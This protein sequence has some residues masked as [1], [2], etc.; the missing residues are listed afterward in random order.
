MIEKVILT[1]FNH[2]HWGYVLQPVLVEDTSGSLNVLSIVSEQSSCFQVLTDVQ[3]QIVRYSQRYA[4]EVLMKSY[5][6]ER[7][8]FDF[9]KTVKPNIIEHY[10][11]PIIE[12][13]HLKIVSLLFDSGMELYHRSDVKKRILYESDHIHYSAEPAHVVFHFIRDDISGLRYF[14]RIKHKDSTIDLKDKNHAVLRHEP[15]VVAVDDQLF[16][17]DDIDSKKLLPFFTKDYISVPATSEQAYIKKFVVNCVRNYE[18]VSEGLSI[19]EVTPQRKACLSLEKDL[20]NQTRL[21]LEFEYE[22]KRYFADDKPQRIVTPFIENGKN[23]IE[24]FERDKEWE[25]SN[26]TLLGE[27]GLERDMAGYF[28]VAGQAMSSGQELTMIHWLQTHAGLLEQFHFD[29]QISDKTYFL[30]DVTMETRIDD[31]QDWFDVK[32]IVVIGEYRIPFT[33]FKNHIL[34]YQKEYLLPDGSVVIL[35]DEWFS[36]YQELM[37]FGKR[38][39]ESFRLSKYYFPIIDVITNKEAPVSQE[40]DL[41]DG[42]SRDVPEGINATLRPY[43]KRGFS[44]LV[45]LYQKGYGGCLADDMGLGKTLQIICLLQYV[46]LLRKDAVLPVQQQI[47]ATR[48][49]QLSILFDDKAGADVPYASSISSSLVVV[50]TS[51]LHN[52]Q[53]ELKRFAP[54][55]RVYPYVGIKRQKIQDLANYLNLFDVVLTTYGILR[56]DIEQLADCHFHCLILDESQQVKNP[57][58]LSFKAVKSISSMHRFILTGTPIE[59]S[60]S[61]LWAQFE[62]VNPGMLGAFASFKKAFIQPITQHDEEREKALL[63]LIQ[64]FILRRAKRDVA[65]ELP[66]LLEEVVYC[67]MSESQQ[68]LYEEEKSRLRNDLMDDKLSVDGQNA[69]F[70]TLQ[71]LTRLRLIANHP[72]LYDDTNPGD[73]GKFEQVAVYLELLRAERHKVLVFS[74]FVKHLRLFADYFDKKKWKYAWLTGETQMKDR[75]TEINRFMKDDKVGCFFISLKAGGVGLNLTAADYV[76]ILDPWWNPASEMQAV[77]R[78]HRIGQGSNVM[79]YRFISTNTIEEKIRKL[80]EGKSKLA[81]TFIR[82][83]N[84]LAGMSREEMDELLQ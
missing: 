60:L 62:L 2:A 41:S 22:G 36:R 66:P 61:D 1:L 15:A 50:P 70:M 4:D 42:D 52:W 8:V 79:V 58:S 24:W 76:F 28:M 26:I 51:L 78:S 29:Q 45:N 57:S 46:G 16:V 59:N 13:Y 9:Y 39:G 72:C 80:Q 35:P 38:S 69:A 34:N 7:T 64:P 63:R 32:C 14:I 73:S 18:V 83:S 37:Y 33:K 65:P 17:F 68:I 20:M 23:R 10:I 21:L 56:N 30:G 11:R 77:A 67:D 31:Q 75:E 49:G 3:Q 19:A 53:N 74:S 5:S 40:E 54:H 82:S 6:K 27:H 84:P 48:R 47:S 44:W 12:Q 25:K 71:G 43:Q 55:L 81:E